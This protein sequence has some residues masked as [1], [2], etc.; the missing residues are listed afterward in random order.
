MWLNRIFVVSLLLFFLTSGFIAGQEKVQEGLFPIQHFE[1]E[2][3]MNASPQNMDMLQDN[4]G[5]M[6]FAN[7][8]GVL[9]YDGHNWRLKR[10]D[11][12]TAVISL[13]QHKSGRIYVGAVGAMGFL[14]P[15]INGELEYHDLTK[16]LHDSLQN[17]KDVKYIHVIDDRVFFQTNQYLFEWNGEQFTHWRS[18]YGFHTSFVVNGFLLVN[19]PSKGLFWLR[20]G[21]LV[22]VKGDRFPD[23]TTIFSFQE[24]PVKGY[25]LVAAGYG[26]VYKAGL[27]HSDNDLFI[28]IESH[29]VINQQLKDVFV[30]NLNCIS[31]SRFTIGTWSN[32]MYIINDNDLVYQLPAANR[33]NNKTIYTQFVDQNKN[34]WVAHSDGLTHIDIQP[35]I[36]YFDE[37]MGIE[38]TI[39]D[40]LRYENSVYLAGEH[41][42]FSMFADERDAVKAKRQSFKLIKEFRGG[43]LDLV[44]DS[45]DLWIAENTSVLK[46]DMKTG[47]TPVMTNCY[48][49]ALFQTQHYPNK[50]FV[51]LDNGISVLSKS[52]NGQVAEKKLTGIKASVYNFCADGNGHVWAG[53]LQNGIFKLQPDENKGQTWDVEQFDTTQDLPPNSPAYVAYFDGDILIGTDK[54][55]YTFNEKNKKF[56][57]AI[58]YPDYLNHKKLLIHNL[59]TD[60][61]RLWATT[62]KNYTDLQIGY[63]KKTDSGYS[64]IDTPFKPISRGTI[65]AIYP[66]QK[67]VVWLGG[68]EGVYRY[69]EN[70]K[71]DYNLPYQAII[72]RVVANKDSVIFAGNYVDQDGKILLKQTNEWAPEISYDHNSLEFHFSA[73]NT[74]VAS[75]QKYSFQLDGFDKRWSEWSTESTRYYTNLV[76]GDYVF[77]V[78][79]QNIYGQE[80]KVAIYRFSVAPPWYRTLFAYFTYLILLVVSV[81]LIV[82][83]YTRYLRRVIRQ[84]TREVVKQ[85]KLVEEKNEAITDSIRYAQHIQKAMLPSVHLLEDT[86]ED[87]FILFKPRDIVSGDFYWFR[88][89]GD[90]TVI[91][92]ADCTG[93]G[94]PG[95]FVS[96]LGMAFLNEIT[97]TLNDISASDVLNKL[98]DQV[99]KSLRQEEKESMSREG[100]DLALYVIDK[101]NMKIEF[102]G[103][104]NPLVIVRNGEVIH[105]KGDRM[106]I[107]HYPRMRDFQRQ[108]FE[109]QNGDMLYTFSDGYQ[110]Q[111]GGEKLTKFK[112]KRLKELFAEISNKPIAEQKQILD[113]T[114]T[115]WMGD[116]P[117]LDDILVMGIRI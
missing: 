88:N 105:I 6:Y 4:R 90:Y 67:G 34:L 49:W 69:N 17:F 101:Q 84:K 38:G 108:V 60:Q 68:T 30:Y 104:N 36:T 113:Y 37:N 115:S 5:V 95:A 8:Q 7:G 9:V 54:G 16:K 59:K 47:L 56:E 111:F 98:R 61:E 85:K 27:K 31:D 72:R 40:I 22:N 50:I 3:Y 93:H 51:G 18:A 100:M 117:Q 107:G 52:A 10:V 66:D 94:V 20:Q 13:G 21:E 57:P 55:L 12:E 114:I 77:K 110:D 23:K 14:E 15:N 109:I 43:A 116:E 73:M 33:L 99:I 112:I 65:H 53:S 62:F 96:M 97:S 11:N 103:A 79:A 24:H 70:I 71:N 1:P 74:E 78:K 35:Q 19:V 58:D 26:G 75:P 25:Y 44:T 28:A 48:P 87:Y 32:G 91:V 86:L 29:G 63:V 102:A 64:W 89:I 82:N 76:E 46:G 2:H 83:F 42:L 41:G 92:A 80:S 81:Y 39:E 106:P 45:S